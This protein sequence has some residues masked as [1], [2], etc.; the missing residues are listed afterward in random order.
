MYV[1]QYYGNMSIRTSGNRL[2][3]AMGSLGAE[4]ELDLIA[5]PLNYH[6]RAQNKQAIGCRWLDDGA[7]NEIVEFIV[8]KEQVVALEFMGSRYDRL[9]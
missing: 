6:L 2:I 9:K 7:N 3:F 4:D 5:H 1:G 8:V